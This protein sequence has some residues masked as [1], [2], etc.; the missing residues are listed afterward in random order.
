MRLGDKHGGILMKFS[1][2]DYIDNKT[3]SPHQFH[4]NNLPIVLSVVIDVT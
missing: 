2:S 3:L 4:E 1:P